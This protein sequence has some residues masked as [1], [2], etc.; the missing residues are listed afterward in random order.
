MGAI[1]ERRRQ[2]R[3]VTLQVALHRAAEMHTSLVKVVRAFA[4][5]ENWAVQSQV[6]T[7]QWVGDGNPHDMAI[8][9]LK[10]WN[11]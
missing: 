7:L 10:K 4:K 3:L 6:D 1:K 9:A 11:L 8:E 2:T 5:G